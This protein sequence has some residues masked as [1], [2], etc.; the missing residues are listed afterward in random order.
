MLS[1][2]LLYIHRILN[3][4]RSLISDVILVNQLAQDSVKTTVPL[5]LS[6]TIRKRI[7]EENVMGE[8]I[9]GVVKI[10][11]GMTPPRGWRFCDGSL[12]SVAEFPDLFSTIGTIYGGDGIST[13]ALPDLRGRVPVGEGRGPGLTYRSLGQMYGSETVV[14]DVNNLPILISDGVAPMG[15]SANRSVAHGSPRQDVDNMQP[16]ITLNYI[17]CCEGM[18]T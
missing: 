12:L 2:F 5:N 10:F 16:S 8:D 13:F 11:A 9:V 4:I 1:I 7:V 17:I 14:I 18:R 3:G 15:Q 6:V